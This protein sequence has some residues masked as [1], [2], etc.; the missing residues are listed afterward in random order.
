MYNLNILQQ[1]DIDISKNKI[2]SIKVSKLKNILKTAKLFKHSHMFFLNGEIILGSNK[3]ITFK[4]DYKGDNIT[5]HI[6]DIERMLQ[7]AKEY[8]LK[9]LFILVENNTTYI[10]VSVKDFIQL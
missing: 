3:Y 4:H 7:V 5:Y 10:N 6:S 8:N 2:Q 9:H 1:I